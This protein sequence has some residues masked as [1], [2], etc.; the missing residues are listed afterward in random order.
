MYG[1]V[2]T[3]LHAFIDWAPDRLQIIAHSSRVATATEG[4]SVEKPFMLIIIVTMFDYDV[5]VVVPELSG[6]QMVVAL[7][8]IK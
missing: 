1:T 4:M 6:C 3:I 5:I 2:C 7:F 8:I